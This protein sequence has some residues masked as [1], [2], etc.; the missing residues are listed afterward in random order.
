ML[1]EIDYVHIVHYVAYRANRK[2]A[3]AFEWDR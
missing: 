1:H 2:L 3:Y